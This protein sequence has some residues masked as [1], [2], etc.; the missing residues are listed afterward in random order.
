MLMNFQ[1]RANSENGTVTKKVTRYLSS[2]DTKW[3]PVQ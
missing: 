2:M 3:Q 1:S